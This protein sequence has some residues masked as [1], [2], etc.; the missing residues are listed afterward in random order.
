MK[1]AIVHHASLKATGTTQPG[2]TPKS[3]LTRWHE[4]SKK[5]KVKGGREAAPRSHKGLA[6]NAMGPAS[7]ESAKCQ[8]KWVTGKAGL[9]DFPKAPGLLCGA[10]RPSC[11]WHMLLR[12][13]VC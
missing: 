13:V 10:V 3:S 7:T 2:R 5:D 12:Y 11:S 6:G 9:L 8:E 4:P 1:G